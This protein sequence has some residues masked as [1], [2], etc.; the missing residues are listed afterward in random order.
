MIVDQPVV[1]DKVAVLDSFPQ[2]TGIV[3]IEEVLGLMEVSPEPMAVATVPQAVVEQQSAVVSGAAKES[4]KG[5]LVQ[6][7]EEEKPLVI[8]VRIEVVAPLAQKIREEEKEESRSQKANTSVPD[9]T[10]LKGV[11]NKSSRGFFGFFYNIGSG[12]YGFVAS[13]FSGVW[14]FFCVRKS[15]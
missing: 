8:S 2:V 13:C 15:K 3:S 12:V 6:I 10:R 7:V 14:N 1:I 11:E 9:D 5:V 4:A